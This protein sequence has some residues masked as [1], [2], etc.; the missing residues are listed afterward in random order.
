M[1]YT[2][3]PARPLSL[4]GRV[5]PST[6]VRSV[7]GILCQSRRHIDLALGNR[8]ERLLRRNTEHGCRQPEPY[9]VRPAITLERQ[10]LATLV[11]DRVDHVWLR[12]RADR[13]ESRSRTNLVHLHACA[14]EASHPR[15][16]LGAD[17][18]DF[19]KAD[20]VRK[21]GA[22]HRPELRPFLGVVL[23]RARPLPSRVYWIVVGHVGAGVE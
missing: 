12:Q 7:S 3:R 6:T 10:F 23:D 19:A 8:I 14:V 16:R 9:Q 4:A 17:Q 1:V 11:D 15:F 18:E 2:T 13:C 21:L 22:L 20:D 5:A